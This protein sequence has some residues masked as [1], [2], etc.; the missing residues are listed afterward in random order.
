M[1][2]APF[3]R[4]WLSGFLADFGDG[5][6]LAAFPLLAVQLTRS[7]TAVAGRGPSGDGGLG[8]VTDLQVAG[9]R[10]GSSECVTLSDGAQDEDAGGAVC[11]VGAPNRAGAAGGEARAGWW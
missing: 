7:P 2:H 5:V 8:C 10:P 6:R 3:A 4:Y 1:F 11:A 9:G